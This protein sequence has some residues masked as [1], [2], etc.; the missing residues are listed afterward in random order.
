MPYTEHIRTMEKTL[1]KLT[2]SDIAITVIS[3]KPVQYKMD[4]ERLE[5]LES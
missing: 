5:A 1:E 3:T 2:T 4:R